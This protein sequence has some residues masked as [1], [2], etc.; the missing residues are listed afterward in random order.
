MN[1]DVPKRLFYGAFQDVVSKKAF[2]ALHL[3]QLLGVNVKQVLILN[4][5]GDPTTAPTQ[6]PTKDPVKVAAAKVKHSIVKEVERHD[7]ERPCVARSS[8]RPCSSD[9]NR[10]ALM[11]CKMQQK[12]IDFCTPKPTSFPT[13]HPTIVS[14]VDAAEDAVD[15]ASEGPSATPTPAPTGTP[16]AA[17]SWATRNPTSRPTSHFGTP[18]SNH[19]HRRRLSGVGGGL[20]SEA[21]FGVGNEKFSFTVQTNVEKEKDRMMRNMGTDAFL[22][23]LKTSLSG[24]S[25]G[26][27]Q[28]L[29]MT[30]PISRYYEKGQ[31]IHESQNLSQ[32]FAGKLVYNLAPLTLVPTP[33]PTIRP[34]SSG[35]DMASLME[36]LV[37]LVFLLFVLRINV[38]LGKLTRLAD[39]LG[40]ATPGGTTYQAVNL[41]EG[42]EEIP[43]ALSPKSSTNRALSAAA[44]AIG[45]ESL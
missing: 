44:D 27:V 32:H 3:S 24:K 29:Q 43:N 45:E 31:Y 10:I 38:R 7:R 6:A 40:E 42:Y 5:H 28:M 19:H 21:M 14:W 8:L 11:V 15:I 18:A 30:T 1:L 26:V 33:M 12:D 41:N 25:L 20:L 4:L 34:I 9:L 39:I 23:Y 37:V 36:G 13:T 35:A 17:P 2:V 16:T 22:M